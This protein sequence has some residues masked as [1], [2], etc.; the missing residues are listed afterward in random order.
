MVLCS[1]VGTSSGLF[2][3]RL[4]FSMTTETHKKH[5]GMFR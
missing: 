1:S 4:E 3:V 2:E 5:N